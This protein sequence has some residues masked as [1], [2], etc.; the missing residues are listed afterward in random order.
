[1]PYRDLSSDDSSDEHEEKT[2]KEDAKNSSP[3]TAQMQVG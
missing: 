1:M 2:K 3:D